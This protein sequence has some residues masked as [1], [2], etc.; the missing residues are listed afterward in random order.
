[1]KVVAREL[2]LVA[3]RKDVGGS[4]LSMDQSLAVQIRQSVDHGRQHL[5]G[6][7]GSKRAIRN[8]LGQRFRREFRHHVEQFSTLG[9]S[10]TVVKDVQKMGLGEARRRL[11]RGE[12]ERAGFGLKGKKFDGRWWCPR[13]LPFRPEN[14]AISGTAKPLEEGESPGDYASDPITFN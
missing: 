5:A 6:F 8:D 4:E 3:D 12:S 11:P 2:Q 9:M 14:M 1:M 7:D 13:P 10:A